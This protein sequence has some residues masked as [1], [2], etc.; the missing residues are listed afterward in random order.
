MDNEALQIAN[1]GIEKYTPALK[2]LAKTDKSF[3]RFF[4]VDYFATGEGRSIW[5]KICRNYQSYDGVDREKR[6][7][8]EFVGH[9]YYLQCSEEQTEKEFM[10]RYE[11]LIPEHVKVQVYRRDQPI[12]TWET[13]LHVNYS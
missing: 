7:W 11:K 3:Y 12:F 2:E 5:L 8:E 13:H 4:V 10:E 1:Q 6:R 9:E